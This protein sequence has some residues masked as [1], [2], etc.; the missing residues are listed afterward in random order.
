MLGT[1]LKATLHEDFFPRGITVSCAEVWPTVNHSSQVE[2]KE[3]TERPDLG[4]LARRWL[5]LLLAVQFIRNSP[6]HLHLAFFKRGVHDE[7]VSSQILQPAM[8]RNA[9]RITI[10]VTTFQLNCFP[11]RQVQSDG[12]RKQ[13]RKERLRACVHFSKREKEIQGER[14]RQTSQDKKAS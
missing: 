14:E 2:D 11:W 3:C 8:A 6:S 10:H 5:L 1:N 9:R 12:Q 4:Q 7:H 13:R